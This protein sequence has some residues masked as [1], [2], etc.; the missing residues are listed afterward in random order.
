MEDKSN[1]VGQNASRLLDESRVMSG[2]SDPAVSRLAGDGSQRAFHR[3]RFGD[4]QCFIAIT[5][6]EEQQKGVAEALSSWHI[7]R[8]LF[9][10]GVPVPEYFAFDRKTGLILCEDLGDMSLYEHVTGDDQSEKEILIVYT[11]VIDELVRMQVDGAEGFQT[12]WCWQTPLY[13]RRLMLERE[14]DYF[15][16]SLVMT[17]SDLPWSPISSG[18]NSTILPAERQRHQPLIFSIVIF[19]AATLC[20]KKAGS[21]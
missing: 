14:S 20:S 8:H 11:Q 7:G 21:G 15:L 19:K 3:I 17:I 16:H 10:K 1:Q 2:A 12:S 4:G 9:G 13:D 6:S 18:L 5:P